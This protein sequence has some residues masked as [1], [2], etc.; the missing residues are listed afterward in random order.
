MASIGVSEI[1][2]AKAIRFLATDVATRQLG[3][4][5]RGS[6]LNSKTPP[7]IK[8]QVLGSGT[9]LALRLPLDSAGHVQE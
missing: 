8:E 9:V 3:M 7:T 5:R 1:D 6:Y 2:M 4:R